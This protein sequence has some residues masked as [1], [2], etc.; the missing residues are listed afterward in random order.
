MREFADAHHHG[1]EEY[2]LFPALVARG[3][4][5][6]NGPVQV[7]CSEQE[8]GRRMMSE[9]AAAI[10]AYADGAAA[11]TRTNLGQALR[12]IA[13]FYDRHIGKEDNVL[14]PMAGRILDEDSTA[15]IL[16]AFGEVTMPAERLR[17]SSPSPTAC[18]RTG[19]VSLRRGSLAA[20]GGGGQDGGPTCLAFVRLPLS[21]RPDVSA[22]RLH[23]SHHPCSRSGICPMPNRTATRGRRKGTAQLPSP[24]SPFS[25][26]LRTAPRQLTRTGIRGYM[27]DVGCHWPTRGEPQT[28]DQAAADRGA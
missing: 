24:I 16:V 27:A 12:A 1:K 28:G 18:D 13:E 6:R 2:R 19:M 8:A 22:D 3:L 14:F 9:L 17:K 21:Q 15:G 11:H 20:R 23:G 5:A 10:D 4:P 7:M 26:R 25:S